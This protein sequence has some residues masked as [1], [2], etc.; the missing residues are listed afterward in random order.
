MARMGAQGSA[1][2]SFIG[3]LA[4]SARQLVEELI[5]ALPGVFKPADFD[6]DLVNY[7]NENQQAA[8]VLFRDI[9]DGR[10]TF[11]QRSTIRKMAAWIISE[12]KALK[13]QRL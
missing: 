4:P 3:S 8:L 5:Q 11:A 10:N 6:E 7:I 1:G 2:G 9:L 12:I 13:R